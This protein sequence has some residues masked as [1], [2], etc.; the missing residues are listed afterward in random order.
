MLSS[1]LALLLTLQYVEIGQ[2]ITL[3]AAPVFSFIHQ[4]VVW[5]GE[6]SLWFDQRSTL[7]QRLHEQQSRL[8][9]QTALLQK[10]NSLQTENIQLRRLLH[11]KNIHG[12]RWQ[13]AQVLGR[14]PDEK[15][16]QLMLKSGNSHEDDIVVSSEGLV[17]LVERSRGGYAIVRTI[18]DAS[19]AVPVTIPDSD[20]AALI[21]GEGKQLTLDF[22]PASFDLKPGDIL[23]SSGAGGMYPPGIAV[24]EVTHAVLADDSLFAK[25]IAVPVAHWQ[26]D[27]WLA[28]ASTDHGNDEYSSTKNPEKNNP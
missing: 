25:V 1:L 28:I 11:L 20:L 24:A 22:V 15:S 3:W 14:S 9:S 13:A 5:A 27:H 7:H 2:R 16:R 6:F 4:P 23:Y 21:R 18:L 17:G 19:I 10:T 8:S 26:R 12:Y